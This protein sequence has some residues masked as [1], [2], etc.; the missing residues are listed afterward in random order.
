MDARRA[1]RDV[2]E[3]DL[4][5]RDV[6]V[7]LE[8]VV[9]DRPDVLPVGAVACLGELQLAHQAAVLGALGIRLDLVAGDVGLYEESEFHVRRRV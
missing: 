4:R 8:E 7:L 5:R 1:G 6:R 2:G 3:E 9:L